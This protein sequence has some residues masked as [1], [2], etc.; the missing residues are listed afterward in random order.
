MAFFGDMGRFEFKFYNPLPKF[1]GKTL[2]PLISCKNVAASCSR[3]IGANFTWKEAGC[4]GDEKHV[5]YWF[6]KNACSAIFKNSSIF[7]RGLTEGLLSSDIWDSP[8]WR[9]F[10][11][12]E[13]YIKKQLVSLYYATVKE[14]K[15]PSGMENK[16]LYLG[17]MLLNFRMKLFDMEKNSLSIAADGVT[18]SASKTKTNGEGGD[19][20]DAATF[21][22]G[23]TVSNSSSSSSTNQTLPLYFD[24]VFFHWKV[25]FVFRVSTTYYI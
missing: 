12:T 13:R 19:E 11:D 17:D 9:Y 10:E 16:I 20:E 3:W 2:S 4:R 1:T 6:L 18:R 5:H 7:P 24:I 8:V 21:N 23:G 22:N 15:E 14:K 25:R